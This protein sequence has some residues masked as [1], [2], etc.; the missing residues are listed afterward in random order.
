MEHVVLLFHYDWSGVQQVFGPYATRESA[1]SAMAELK[2]W[3]TLR[4]EWQ[5]KP[6]T[7]HGR[8][9]PSAP[10]A[11]AAPVVVPVPYQAPPT[12]P[13]PNNVW[14]EVAAPTAGADIQR[15][16]TYELD[17]HMAHAAAAAAA[18]Q[19]FGWSPSQ[20]GP[21]MTPTFTT[22]LNVT[23]SVV[24]SDELA[25]S[26]RQWR[27]RNGD[28]TLKRIQDELDDPDDEDPPAAVAAKI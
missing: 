18:M 13:W 1:E 6:L 19:T 10:A 5:V 12:Y 4:G 27:L 2:T 23:G 20:L 22:M 11:P 8:S 16:V 9:T 25:A 15:G 7:R 17:E 21:A 28:Q 24:G 26:F 3:P 14:C